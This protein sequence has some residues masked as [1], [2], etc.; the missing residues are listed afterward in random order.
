MVLLAQIDPNELIDTTG[1]GL[2]EAILAGAVLI[3]AVVLGAVLRRVVV[4][5]ATRWSKTKPDVAVLLGRLV[6]WFVAL[7][8][9]VAALMIV[10]FQ[11]GPMFLILSVIAVVVFLSARS[12]LE[13]FGAGIILQ[14]EGPFFIGDLVEVVGER[15][16]VADITGR[17]TVLDTY[18]GRRLRIPNGDVLG[19]VIVNYSERRA[20]R[21]D[22]EVGVEYGT[23]LDHA[24]TV[25]LAT[26][27]EVEGVVQHPEPEAFV[28]GFGESSIDFVARFWHE[29]TLDSIYQLTDTVARA[30]AR[31]F[32]AEGIVIA[33]PQLVVWRGPEPELPPDSS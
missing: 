32:R 20:L 22:L 31:R 28:V 30:I 21:T 9:L 3:V 23:D 17:A 1:V 13:N 25:L 26:M 19:G 16:T 8:G 33:F 11:L 27:K 10:G 5:M 2:Q 12:L 29:P 15:G 6:G 24:R 7:L 14:T 18:D 4:R